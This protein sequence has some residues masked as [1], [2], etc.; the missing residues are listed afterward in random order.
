MLLLAILFTCLINSNSFYVN[1]TAKKNTVFFSRLFERDDFIRE[2]IK[3][4]KEN[5]LN[6]ENK[7]KEDDDDN[8]EDSQEENNVETRSGRSVDQDGKTNIWS[9]EPTMKLQENEANN[10][11]KLTGIFFSVILVTFQ[12]FLLANPIFPDP[13]DY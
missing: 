1:K 12:I 5:N 10:L 3:I 2:D 6:L 9:I 13:S 8:E 7:K 11:L 4:N